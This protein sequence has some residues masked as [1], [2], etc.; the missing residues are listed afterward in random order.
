MELDEEKDEWHVK[1]NYVPKDFFRI[2][3]GR[4]LFAGYHDIGGKLFLFP[5][6]GNGMICIS[7]EK[8]ELYRVHCTD[9]VVQK[10][11]KIRKDYLKEQVCQRSILFEGEWEESSLN[12]MLSDLLNASEKENSVSTMNM[13]K[14]NF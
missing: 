8:S 7:K 3:K 12:Y 10:T 14:T 5:R 9:E 6:R 1:P 2:K 13:G 4:T 11:K